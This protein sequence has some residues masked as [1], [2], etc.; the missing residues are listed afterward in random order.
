MAEEIKKD[1]II[2]FQTKGADKAEKTTKT[3]NKETSELDNNAK[4]SNKSFTK[5]SKGGLKNFTSGL[6]AVGGAL[7]ALGIGLLL[8]LVAKLT[9]VLSRNQKVVDAVSTVFETLN[10]FIN[11]I[12]TAF[13]NA[14]DRIT[15]TTDGFD[16]M[17]KVVGGLITIALTPLKQLFNGI[18]LAVQ[19]ARL[20]WEQSFFGDGDQST[21]DEL[22]A[23]IKET[24]QDIK[25]TG[26][27]A[28]KAGKQVKD[29]IGEA[30][31]EVVNGAKTTV[32]ELSKVSISAAKA[33]AEQLVNI[34]NE[35]EIAAAEIEKSIFKSQ[36]AAEKQR[37]IRDDETKS[38]EER[39]QANEE[40][41][42]ILE[43]QQKNELALAQTR[44][45]AAQQEVEAGNTSTQAKVA[46]INAEKELL[47]V[48]ERIAGFESEQQLNRNALERERLEGI[49]AQK[50]A[51]NALL[52]EKQRINAQEIE[53]ERTRLET[54]KEIAEE[55]RE[56]ELQR[57]QEKIESTNKGT[58]ARIDA[59]IEFAQRKFE[60]DQQVAEQDKKLNDTKDKIKDAEV[61]AEQ[62]KQKTLQKLGEEGIQ[63]GAQALGLGKEFA[64]VKTLFE[65]FQSARSAFNTQLIPGDPTSLPRAIGAAAFATV[66]GLAD[67]ASIKAIKTPS[68]AGA[69]GSGGASG[70]GATPPAPPAFNLVG[71]GATSSITQTENITDDS[72][73][74]A[75]V[76]SREMTSQQ[77]ADANAE[78]QSTF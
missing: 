64:I 34:R 26:E 7:K 69:G 59:E 49:N 11:Q 31:A 28:I 44:L 21:I 2:D 73:V 13:T 22:N 47:D 35:A 68:V 14:Y 40:L 20:A 77:Q 63:A 45:D 18:K 27:E 39:K 33:Q 38:I 67:V 36:L 56:F 5:L 30:V 70:G 74:Q 54:L 37:Q 42:R 4:K 46:V 3:I 53:D 50:E 65:T 78:Q 29:N 24:K 12:I 41:G 1:V 58:Q 72:P 60:L 8:G 17:K 55:E 48:K 61:K 16:A 66:S 62:S 10:I 19:E 75:V 71:G 23:S 15:E 51:E 9:D 57:L 32:N 76:V 52:F 6:K 43:Q 25:D